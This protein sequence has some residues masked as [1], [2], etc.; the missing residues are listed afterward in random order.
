MA[1]PTSLQV[2]QIKSPEVICEAVEGDLILVNF[3]S[4]FYYC[5]RGLAA[6]IMQAILN[7]ANLQ[8]L[9]ASLAQRF[10][11]RQSDIERDL[12]SFLEALLA[13]GLIVVRSTAP[14]SVSPEPIIGDD[15]EPPRYEKFED[16]A[17][18]LLLDKIEDENQVAVW[19]TETPMIGPQ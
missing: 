5:I 18:Q 13:E 14:N 16:M 8:T 4:G 3:E 15:Y 9:I 2:Y 7:G 12:D 6:Q 10:P 1:T 17:D 11:G 19:V